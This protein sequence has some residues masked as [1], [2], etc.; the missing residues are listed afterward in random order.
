MKKNT[1]KFIISLSILLFALVLLITGSSLLNQNLMGIPSGNVITWLGFIALQLSIYWG[2]YNFDKSKSLP[3]RII[4]S[5]M[6]TLIIISVLWFGLA[7]LLSGNINFN[8]KASPDFIGSTKASN[9]FWNINYFIVLAP[10]ILASIYNLIRF[11]EIRK[12]RK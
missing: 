11:L 6:I 3:V 10:I 2:H 4:K 8:F 7:Y 1:I 5:I 12:S 9:L